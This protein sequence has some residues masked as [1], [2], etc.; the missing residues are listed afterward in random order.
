MAES[1]FAPM[2]ASRPGVTIRERLEDLSVDTSE[3]A[4]RLG[5]S[6]EV[7]A[8]LLDGRHV[9]TV[10]L[11]RRL[12]STLGASSEYWIN[13]DCQYREDLVRVATDDWLQEL[14]IANM[15]EYGWLEDRGEDWASRV[16]EC[17]SFFDVEDVATWRSTYEPLLADVRMRT[18][19]KH[20]S[21]D[22]AVAAWLRQAVRQAHDIP[23]GAW[24]A[25]KLRAA[26][27][28]LRKLTRRKDPA[29]FLPRLQALLADV[30]VALVVVRA[31]PG[32]PASGAARKLPGNAALIVVSMRFLVDDQFWFTVFH[33]IGHL[34]LDH[35]DR[36]ILDDP[37]DDQ[38]DSSQERE[39]NE[40]AAEV[41]LP[42]A[43]RADIP[44]GTLGHR[45]IVEL[46][47]R[48]GVS[49]GVVVGQ[50]QHDNRIPQKHL[51]WVKRRYRWNGL[52]LE[53]A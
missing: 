8:R 22:V 23:V 12:A 2:W 24:D 20:A 18:S 26:L 17:L 49:P 14:P 46:A 25:D 42:A 52:N 4:N 53:M 3:F 37:G 27:P 28:E 11:A 16:H 30:G 38:V 5:E 21:S 32:C 48:A 45:Q 50:L 13:R 41:L 35:A 39:A 10:D 9:I 44:A 33:E 7:V 31:L 34:L 51:N 15:T 6:T 40:F 36:P 19:P 43:L 1:G 29:H 47:R